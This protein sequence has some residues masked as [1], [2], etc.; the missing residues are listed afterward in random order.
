MALTKT[1]GDL[2]NTKKPK[3]FVIRVADGAEVGEH[4]SE[5]L[6]RKRI[7]RY[8]SM[9]RGRLTEDAFKIIGPVPRSTNLSTKEK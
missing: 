6:A 9:S 5:A 8:I 3:F 2:K 1:G 7:R 4:S